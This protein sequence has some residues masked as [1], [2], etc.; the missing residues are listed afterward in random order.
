MGKGKG[1]ADSAAAKLCLWT[2]RRG[3]GGARVHRRFLVPEALRKE[4]GKGEESARKAGPRRG[5]VWPLKSL[6]GARTSEE[7][8]HAHSL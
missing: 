2:V 6:S 7:S 4:V 1:E 3:K 5:V 8:K